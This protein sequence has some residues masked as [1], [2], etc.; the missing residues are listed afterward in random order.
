MKRLLNFLKRHPD[1]EIE[2]SALYRTVLES[3]REVQA[4]ARSHGGNIEL[5]DVSDEGDVKVRFRG[6]CAH[7]PLSEL[8]LKQG[9]VD[10]LKDLVPEVRTVVSV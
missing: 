3:M 5:V 8:T 10:R 6:S 7:C 2:R 1:V 9:V 4:Y